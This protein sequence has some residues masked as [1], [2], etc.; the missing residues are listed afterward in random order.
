MSKGTYNKTHKFNKSVLR[1][2]MEES[3]NFYNKYK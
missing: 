2:V 3:K 1:K